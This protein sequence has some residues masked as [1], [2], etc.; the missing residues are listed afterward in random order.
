MSIKIVHLIF[1]SVS[2]LLAF[3]FGAWCI[4]TYLREK[5]DLYIGMGGTSFL[6][7]IALILYGISFRRKIKRLHL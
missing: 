1:I 4:H 5:S 3:G 6:A 7:G 2:T